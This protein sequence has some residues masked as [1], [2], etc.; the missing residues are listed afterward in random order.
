MHVRVFEF[1]EAAFD[2]DANE[3]C[4]PIDASNNK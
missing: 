4:E 2:F 1:L 3:Y